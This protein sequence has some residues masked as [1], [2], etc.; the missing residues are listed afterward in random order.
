MTMCPQKAENDNALTIQDL[1]ITKLTPI[2]RN[3]ILHT[4]M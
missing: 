1:Q 3:T 4:I 2:H